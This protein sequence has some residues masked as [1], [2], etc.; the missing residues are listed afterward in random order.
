M[1]MLQK[2]E[3]FHDDNGAGLGASHQSGWTGRVPKLIQQSGG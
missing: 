2:N 1:N 3:Y